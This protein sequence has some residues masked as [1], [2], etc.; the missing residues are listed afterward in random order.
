M[1][2]PENMRCSV[3]VLGILCLSLTVSFAMGD[4]TQQNTSNPPKVDNNNVPAV[5]GSL[6]STLAP[7]I[8]NSLVQATNSTPKC[9]CDGALL[10]R[11]NENGKVLE[12]C[13]EC[14]CQHEA[15]K[16]TLIKVICSSFVYVL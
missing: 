3:T 1:F 14:K 11:L 9:V 5:K 12:I 7:N 6:S 13:P 15:R 16:T 4:I 10:P 2:R 8:L